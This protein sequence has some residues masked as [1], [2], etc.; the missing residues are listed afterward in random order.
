LLNRRNAEEPKSKTEVIVSRALTSFADLS[1]KVVAVRAADESDFGF[2]FPASGPQT[3]PS[4]LTSPL[5]Q[6]A[7]HRRDLLPE[8][9]TWR[10]GGINE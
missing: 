5:E 7:E 4:A 8:F 10:H 6:R 9:H 3:T 2:E 1:L